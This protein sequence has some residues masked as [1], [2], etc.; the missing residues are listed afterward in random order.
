MFKTHLGPVAS[1]QSRVYLR[2]ETAQGI[3]VNYRN[4]T[5]STRVPFPFG[6]AQVGKAFRNEIVTKQFIF[7]TCEFEQLEMQY[8]VEPARAD[9]WFA[10]WKEARMDYY[11][12]L[13]IDPARLRLQP[14]G[15]DELAHYA[16]AAV[17]IQ[18]RFPFGWQELEGVHN[19]GDY[20]LTQHSTHSGKELTHR[21][22][23]GET[24]TPYII[25]T[26]AGL[27]RS[28][29]MV[30]CDAYT[31]E[32]AAGSSAGGGSAAGDGA[33]GSKGGEGRTLLRF[34]PRLAPITVAVFPLVK[35]DGLAGIAQRIEEGLRDRFR[36]FYDQSGAVGRRYRRQ[37]EIG[38]PFCV[39]VDYDSKDGKG[40]T[41]RNRDTMEQVRVS[42]DQLE[43]W[44]SGAISSWKRVE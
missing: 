17:D 18:Y 24:F 11:H 39:T 36:T 3:Y 43:G 37:D 26:S 34:H 41:V 23:D 44:I 19:R 12:S 2:P 32:E 35:K 38:T 29:L 13:G 9:H 7:R 8:F 20:D 5:Q 15:E 6:I 27:T 14:H 33:E 22:V 28:V 21:T 30:L 40:V 4:V 10:H 25:E 31:V 1:E 16:R 42:V